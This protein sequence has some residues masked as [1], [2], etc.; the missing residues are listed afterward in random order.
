M[1]LVVSYS[2]LLVIKKSN[3]NQLTGYP[4]SQLVINWLSNDCPGSLLG[5][6]IS[7]SHGE[8]P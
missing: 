6:S 7:L 8:R 4:H 2:Y 1:K 5:L 3:H